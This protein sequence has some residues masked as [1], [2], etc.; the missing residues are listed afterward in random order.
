MVRSVEQASSREAACEGLRLDIELPGALRWVDRRRHDVHSAL[1]L[2]KG[3]LPASFTD[4]AAT[5]TAFGARLGVNGVLVALRG[6]AEAFLSVL[7][8]P[9]G[10]LPRSPLGS[11]ARGRHQQGVGADP[12]DVVA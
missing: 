3:L 2:I 11:G 10:F 8:K 7:P 1:S 5:L 6:I 12:P 9:L 4:C